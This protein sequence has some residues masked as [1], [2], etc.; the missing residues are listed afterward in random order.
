MLLSLHIMAKKKISELIFFFY[1]AA[2]L[3][4]LAGVCDIFLLVRSALHLQI[5]ESISWLLF[6]KIHLGIRHE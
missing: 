4:L 1:F 5:A 2:H 3:W 6:T